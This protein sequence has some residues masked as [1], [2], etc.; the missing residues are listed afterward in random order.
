M[1]CSSIRSA[2]TSTVFSGVAFNRR[3][4]PGTPGSKIAELT[5]P[6]VSRAFK[7]KP[8]PAPTDAVSIVGGTYQLYISGTWTELTSEPGTWGQ[9]IADYLGLESYED[10]DNYL[11]EGI[12]GA[13]KVRVARTSSGIYSGIEPAVLTIAGTDYTFTVNSRGALVSDALAYYAG[14]VAEGSLLS[15]NGDHDG[16]VQPGR[17]YDAET[18]ATIAITGLLTTDTITADS[19]DAPTCTVNGTMTLAAGQIVY[20]VTVTRAD[21]VIGYY[22]CAEGSGTVAFNTVGI[23]PHGVLSS[24]GIH[25]TM[26]DGT[27][28]DLNQDGFT[29][30][31]GLDQYFDDMLQ[32]VIPVDTLIPAASDGTATAYRWESARSHLL[33][34]GINIYGQPAEWE[35][36]EADYYVDSV[37]GDDLNDGTGPNV[38]FATISKLKEQPLADGV[39]IGLAAGSYWREEINLWDKSNCTVIGYGV[40]NRPKVDGSDVADNALFSAVGGTTNVYA[41]TW[42]HETTEARLAVF[43]DGDLLE[44][45]ANEATCDSTPGSYYVP[46]T[47]SSPATVKIHPKNSTNPISDGKQ[48]TIPVRYTCVALGDG[49]TIKNIHTTKQAHKD[50]SLKVNTNGYISNCMGS[51]GSVHNV[52]MTGGICEDTI[53]FGY[54]TYNREGATLFITHTDTVPGISFEYRRCVA[55]SQTGGTQTVGGFYNHSGLVR[56]TSASYVDCASN[57]GNFNSS[58]TDV[59]ILERCKVTNEFPTMSG[60]GSAA[61]AVHMTDCFISVPSSSG[62]SRPVNISTTSTAMISGMRIVMTGSAYMSYNTILVYGGVNTTLEN[63]VVYSAYAGVSVIYGV[64]ATSAQN[65]EFNVRNNIFDYGNAALRPIVHLSATGELTSDNNVFKLAAS[66]MSALNVAYTT[67]A[68]YVA[69][70]GQDIN[71]VIGDPLFTDPANGDFSLQPG[72]PAIAIGAGL[73][74]PNIEYLPI[75]SDEILAQW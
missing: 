72:S 26:S 54:T 16:P 30:A 62:Q 39:T 1:D 41:I 13:S 53:A 25:T 75:P 42:S 47:V 48:Y 46:I 3:G 45:V 33:Y 63:S 34:Q 74:N 52:W 37:N 24:D 43:E 27:G 22:A 40:G 10:I 65:G 15:L 14:D 55:K 31:D 56:F 67:I 60:F 50:G 71:S 66:R 17:G 68:G 20:G 44:W 28:F 7:P 12:V 11:Y 8:L 64:H 57:N 38:A 69:A 73:T 2:V 32:N 51:W 18:G 19:T 70:T 21:E 49:G 35:V 29:V 61:T 59:H 36:P 6:A 5:T 23:L 58:D 9:I 4:L